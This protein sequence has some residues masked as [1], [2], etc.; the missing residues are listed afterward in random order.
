M[1]LPE[2]L[3]GLG[4]PGKLSNSLEVLLPAFRVLRCKVRENF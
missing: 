1:L 4:L 2:G 3:C